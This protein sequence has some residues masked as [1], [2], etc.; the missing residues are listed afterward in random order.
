MIDVIQHI[1]WMYF[2]LPFLLPVALV[3]LAP[4]AAPFALIYAAFRMARFRRR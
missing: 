4:F 1:P 3:I 2:G